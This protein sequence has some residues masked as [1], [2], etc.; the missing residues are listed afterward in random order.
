[1]NSASKIESI[2]IP[3][4]ERGRSLSEFP[5][6]VRLRNVLEAANIRIAG[7]LHNRTYAEVR[8]LRNCGQKTLND[9]RDLVRQLQVGAGELASVQEV[10]DSSLLRVPE[11]ARDLSL[12]ELPLTAR[13][14]NVLTS[15]GYRYLG[16]LEGLDVRQLLDVKNCG[17][18]CVA[19]L[20][21]LLCRV[22]TGEFTTLTATDVGSALYQVAHEIDVGLE[23][24]S[25]RDKMILAARLAGDAG[26]PRTLEYVGTEFRL[27]RERVRQIVKFAMQKIRR[28]GGP[29]MARNLQMIAHK[30]DEF[31]CPFSSL[32]LVSVSQLTS[33]A[34]HPVT[35]FCQ[36]LMQDKRESLKAKRCW[37]G[38]REGRAP[39]QRQRD[40]VRGLFFES[41]DFGLQP[42]LHVLTGL[43]QGR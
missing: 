27:T 37:R 26:N 38:W 14:E 3:N 41:L 10:T 23:A 43:R 1:M 20:N 6:S 15:C 34:V 17:K 19:E 18:K 29:K 30:C 21:G 42:L 4:S 32:A 9:L 28:G 2:F 8:G 31:V 5:V 7:H 16:D 40:S 25:A 22:R 24:L 13:L 39:G 35:S 12:E 33:L 11:K 36:F